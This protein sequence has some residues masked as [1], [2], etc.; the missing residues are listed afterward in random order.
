[1]KIRN[2]KKKTKRNPRLKRTDECK[3]QNRNE[4]RKYTLMQIQ[5]MVENFSNTYRRKKAR[6]TYIHTYYIHT[7]T[8][9]HTYINIYIYI[10]MYIYIYVCVYV[11][12]YVCMRVCVCVCMRKRVCACI[13]VCVCDWFDK[14]MYD[15]VLYLYNIFFNLLF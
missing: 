6:H 5:Y 3:N 1:M 13:C 4:I 14:I 12:M 10:Y 15:F 8:H 9:T 2:I 11:C 7:H